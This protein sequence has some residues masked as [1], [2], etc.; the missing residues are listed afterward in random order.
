MTDSV[1][2]AARSADSSPALRAMARG[3]Y[4]ASGVV[5]LLIG[6]IVLSVALGGQGQTDQSGAFKAIAGAPLGM[7][8][9][10][11]LAVL[12]AALGLFHLVQ[13]F[14]VHGDSTADTWKERLSEAG[15]AVVF[16]GLGVVAGSVALG[17]RPN[18]DRSA[19]TASRDV[20]GLPGGPVLLALI[21]AGVVIGGIVFAA[22]GVRRSFTDKLT[23][24]AGR[25][26]QGV[27]VLGVVG[28]VAK[29]VALAIVGVLLFVAAITVDPK[30]AGGLDAA[31]RT[32]LHLPFGPALAG[33]AGVGFAAYGTFLFFRARYAKL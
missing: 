16:L 20:L 21:G 26:G 8:M 14:L 10:W 33:A 5:H 12:L 28:Y 19:E 1:K 32:L 9:L 7:A 27:T 15:Q 29:G 23:I 3:G 18:G 13:T 22:K 4:A 25:V 11:V 30:K 31:V 6:V 24:P 2:Q 17:S